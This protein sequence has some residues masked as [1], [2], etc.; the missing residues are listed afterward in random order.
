MPEADLYLSAIDL[1]RYWPD[2]SGLSCED[3]LIKLKE[4]KFCPA[5]YPFLTASQLKAFKLILGAKSYLPSVP[6]LTVP[7]PQEAG[8]FFINEPDKNSLVIVSG[9]NQLTFE[10]LATIWA[11]GTTPAYF[12]LV[13]CLGSTIDMAMIYGIFTPA[14]LEKILEE[15]DLEKKVVHRHMIVPGFTAPLAQEFAAVTGWEVEVGPIC[16]VELPLFLGERW[17][18]PG[19]QKQVKKAE[20]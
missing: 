14:R 1:C 15:S 10:V 3:F 2:G 12:L 8:L 18:F 16:A 13:D 17:I 4:E 6:Q 5:D 9:N 19:D 11:Q 7:R 20:R